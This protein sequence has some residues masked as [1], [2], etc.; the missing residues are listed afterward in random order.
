MKVFWTI[1]LY[2]VSLNGVQSS[3]ASVKITLPLVTGEWAPYTGAALYKK[4]VFSEIVTAA[5]KEVDIDT[6]YQFYPWKRAELS[7]KQGVA[8]AALPYIK[9]PERSAAYY[10]SDPITTA[11][12][13]IFYRKEDFPAG[14][15]YQR[16]NDLSAYRM[17]GVLGYWYEKSFADAKLKIEYFSSDEQL[18]VMLYHHRVQLAASAEFVGWAAIKKRYPQYEYLFAMTTEPLKEDDLH[19]MVSKTYPQAPFFL[20]QF[21]LG[22][23]KLREKGILQAILRKNRLPE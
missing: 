15:S 4:G 3:Y 13:A 6:R 20:Q 19:L 11:K 8:F 2:L 23:A 10:F 17:G 9:T 22:L 7:L 14:F 18:F 16:F 5:F 21:N 1:L 12:F